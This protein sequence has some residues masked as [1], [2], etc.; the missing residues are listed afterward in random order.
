MTGHK[1]QIIVDWDGTCVIPAWPSQPIEWMPGAV[2]ALHDMASYANVLIFSARLNPFEPSTTVPRPQE[3]VDEETAYIRRMLDR[4][5][6]HH[7]GIWT[8]PGK[9]TGDLYIDD[10]AERYN[11]RQHSWARL[12]QKVRMRFAQPN[13]Y[14]P[15]WEEHGDGSSDS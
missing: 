10:K 8:H 15:P 5:S 4:E 9:P 7:V 6:L 2:K 11:G 12:A 14:F 3:A 1:H 13:A